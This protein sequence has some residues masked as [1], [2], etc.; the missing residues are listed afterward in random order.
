MYVVSEEIF[1]SSCIRSQ[2]A[3]TLASER[4]QILRLVDGRRYVG[5]NEVCSP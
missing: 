4:E 1:P 3:G 2:A 5:A